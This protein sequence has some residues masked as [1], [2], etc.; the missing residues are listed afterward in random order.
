MKRAA[1]YFL[2]SYGYVALTIFT[3]VYFQLILKWQL[4]K[5]PVMPDALPGKIYLLISTVLTNVYL[6]SA[7][8]AAATGLISWMLAL[9]V[10]P[11][12]TTFPMLSLSY[13]LVMVLSSYIFN[14]QVYALQIVG[15]VFISLGVALLG[16][17]K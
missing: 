11:L 12:S 14:E 6:L 5:M 3:T 7:F 17:S 2:G 16:F 15:L 8:L 9:K 10:L 13:I 1:V 4:V